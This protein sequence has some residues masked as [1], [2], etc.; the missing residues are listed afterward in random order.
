M[1]NTG[2]IDPEKTEMVFARLAPRMV[3][4]YLAPLGFDISYQSQRVCETESRHCMASISVE[5]KK[6]RVRLTPRP[7][8]DVD[9]QVEC[10][11][12]EVCNEL[13]IEQEIRRQLDFTISNY[14]HILCGELD[15]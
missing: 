2:N 10:A 8:A 7:E 14:K 3:R 13:E 4:E 9:I 1:E 5:C 6:I 15:R 12:V 11:A